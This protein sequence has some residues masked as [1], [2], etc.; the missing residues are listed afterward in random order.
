MR[1]GTGERVY[2][3]NGGRPYIAEPLEIG[4]VMFAAIVGSYRV[5]HE[6]E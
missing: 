3:G 2:E 1:A 5:A 6:G 4:T